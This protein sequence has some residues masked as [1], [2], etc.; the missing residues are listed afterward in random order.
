[1][2]LRVAGV[3]E[4]RA[5]AVR[6]PG[7][8]DVAALGVGGEVEDVAVA[9]GGE[10]H[11]VGHLGADLAGDQVPDHDAPG[12]A[13]HDDQLQH[14]VPGVHLHIAEADLPLQRLVRAEQQLLARLALGVEGAL[15]L[16]AAERAGVQQT[17]VLAGERHALRHA[18]VDDVDRD[19]GQPMDVRLAGAEVAALDGVVEQSVHRVAVVAVVL[20]GVDAALRRDR[21]CPARAVLVAVGLHVVALLGQR[22]R[23]RAAGQTGA[24]HDHR[25]LAAVGRV[26][27]LGLEAPGVP[28]LL[29]RAVGSLGVGDRV[30]LGEEFHVRTPIR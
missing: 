25:H 6:A 8:G 21:V 13:V 18:L 2:D 24:D 14:L 17:A 4:V 16:G 11:G 26:D 20:G 29:D 28:A 12:L 3:G 19:L 22:G 7:G 1:M 9:A 23:G 30:A 10:H 15:H 27:Q 5:L